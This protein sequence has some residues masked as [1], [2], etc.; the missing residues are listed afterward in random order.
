MDTDAVGDVGVSGWTLHDAT[1]ATS[2]RRMATDSRGEI[3]MRDSC[4][5]RRIPLP[6][7][8]TPHR[9]D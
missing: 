6:L 5:E 2:E 8:G 9:K 1:R 7:D 4:C 3:D